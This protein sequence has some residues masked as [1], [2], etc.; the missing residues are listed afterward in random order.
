ME[1]HICHMYPDLL[2]MYGDIGNVK[3]L[4]Y[5]AEKRDITVYLHSLAAG[6]SFDCEAF[7]IVLLGSGQDFEMGIV[8]D[9]LADEK[10]EQL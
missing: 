3:I 2:N 5:R 6:E 10:K 1:L 8:S 4:K 7:D 9:D